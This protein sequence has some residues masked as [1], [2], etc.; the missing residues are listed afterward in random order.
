M[1]SMKISVKKRW[2]VVE[3]L[4]AVATL[5]YLWYVDKTYDGGV[6]V[7]LLGIGILLPI[8]VIVG[9]CSMFDEKPQKVQKWKLVCL[10]ILY[11]TSYVVVVWMNPYA[12]C[13]VW[14]SGGIVAMCIGG[15]GYILLKRKLNCKFDTATLL[16]MQLILADVVIISTTLVYIGFLQPMTLTDA[17]EL[18]VQRYGEDQ[19]LYRGMDTIYVIEEEPLGTYKFIPNTNDYEQ[20][21]Y[22]SILDGKINSD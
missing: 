14:I 15:L 8:A 6:D 22:V 21:V 16:A 4:L 7:N 5:L 17:Q 9:Q 13:G 1:E 11:I 3:V 19:Y 18:I 12:L 20:Y 10:V 2:M